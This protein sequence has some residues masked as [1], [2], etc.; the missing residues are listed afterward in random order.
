MRTKENTCLLIGP[1]SVS[2]SES[3]D[4]F[5]KLDKQ[6][7]KRGPRTEWLEDLVK[8]HGKVFI[9]GK[10]GIGKTWTAKSLTLDG[11]LTIFDDDDDFSVEVSTKYALYI[12]NNSSQCP[13]GIPSFEYVP[14]T[15]SETLRG[16]AGMFGTLDT[17]EEPSDIVRRLLRG[18]RFEIPD[19]AE[20]GY[21][22]ALIHENH[23]T[24]DVRVLE[25]LSNADIFDTYIYK[26]SDWAYTNYFVS[27]G[28]LKP[29]YIIDPVN[30]TDLVPG[31][32]WTKH[33]NMCMRRKRLKALYQKGFT[34]DHL[35]LIR[36]HLNEG[37][38]HPSLE[39]QDIDIL[40]HVCK[41]KRAQ[42]LKKQI[43]ERSGR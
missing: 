37:V 27:E 6:K 34:M 43:R 23:K 4:R 9:W 12:G 25:A 10:S 15:S 31:S 13:E 20:R 32:L 21:M 38:I 29:S 26:N 19:I 33:Q 5:L 41:I 28:L 36:D 14:W 3:M 11:S 35:P 30:A 22:Y 2:E 18:E 40:N 8:T 7:T 42:S 1:S 39:V 24:C 17:Y 16:S